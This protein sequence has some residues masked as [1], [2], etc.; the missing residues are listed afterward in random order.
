MRAVIWYGPSQLPAEMCMELI[1]DS[2]PS[3]PDTFG[4]AAGSAVRDGRFD[5]GDGGRS[6]GAGAQS[7]AVRVDPVER[8]HRKTRRAGP[9]RISSPSERGSEEAIRRSPR[10]VPFLLARSSSRAAPPA[11]TIRAW[12]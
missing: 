7:R 4:G 8:K 12:W 5:S 10:N 3:R 6:G 11:T 9:I 1:G 2:L